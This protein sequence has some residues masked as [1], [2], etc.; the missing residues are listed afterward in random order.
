M[1]MRYLYIFSTLF[2]LLSCDKNQANQTESLSEDD[3]YY[4]KNC[5]DPGAIK[6]WEETV[7][8]GGDADHALHA[9][10]LGLC[11]KVLQKKITTER[12]GEIFE[13][14]RKY[15]IA[16]ARERERIIDKIILDSAL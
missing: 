4:T 7:A 16:A 5:I 12:A 10:W 11:L 15:A 13:T 6:H 9:L 3:P 1:G 2:L 14:A 8:D